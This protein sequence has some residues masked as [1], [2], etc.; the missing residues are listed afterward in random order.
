[1]GLNF[2]LC[3]FCD[4]VACGLVC[5]FGSLCVD[6]LVLFVCGLLWYFVV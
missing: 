6:C 4:F 5:V 2:G 1:M 3:W